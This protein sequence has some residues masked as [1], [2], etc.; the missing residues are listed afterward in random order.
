MN[1]TIDDL[2]STIL[3]LPLNIKRAIIAALFVLVLAFWYLLLWHGLGA[4]NAALRAEIVSKTN[5]LKTS[6][7][8]VIN[9]QQQLQ[10]LQEQTALASQQAA[11]ALQETQKK[12]VSPDEMRT[13]LEN[14]LTTKFKLALLEFKTLPT[15]TIISPQTNYQLFEYGI[16]LKFRGDY[17]T[18]IKY[19]LA[20]ENLKWLLFWDKLDYN[21]TRYPNADVTLEIHTLSDQEGWVHA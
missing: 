19:L 20:I 7:D 3:H 17:F 12:I 4:S 5:N 15:K 2:R 10:S 18:T 8:L 6:K 21:V 11:T 14:L 1:F 13:V 16:Q 9:L